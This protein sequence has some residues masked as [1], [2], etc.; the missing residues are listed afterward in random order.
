MRGMDHQ[1][2]HMFSYLSPESAGAEGSSAACPSERMGGRGS[3]AVVR[4]ERLFNKPLG[5]Q[6]QKLKYR[7]G[8]N[9]DTNAGL[10]GI[11]LLSKL[12]GDG[13]FGQANSLIH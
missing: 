12:A 7:V 8:S 3:G 10:H 2:S 13:T 1:Q 11:S 6:K 5:L 4:S 9:S